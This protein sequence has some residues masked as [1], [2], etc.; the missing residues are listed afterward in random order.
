M[1]KEDSIKKANELLELFNDKLNEK[2]SDDLEHATDPY[3]IKDP[4]RDFVH[5]VY[6]YNPNLP[7][8]NEVRGLCGNYF[9][10]KEDIEQ[11]IKLIKLFIKY[12]DEYVVNE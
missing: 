3:Q 11:V 12:L 7:L 10:N 9:M 5:L 1:N 8:Y 2:R 6:T 4:V